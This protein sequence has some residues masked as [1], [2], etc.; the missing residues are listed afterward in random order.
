MSQIK[1]EVDADSVLRQFTE[2]E[3]R[4]L[5]FAVMRAA[6]STAEEVQYQWRRLISTRLDSPVSLT[7][8]SVYLKKARYT[9]G[10]DG[11]RSTEAAEVYIRDEAAKG[12]PP[13]KYLLAQVLGGAGRAKGIDRG[14]QRAGVLRMGERAIPAHDSTLLDAHGNIKNGVVAQI[15]SQLGGQF[16]ILSNESPA[17]KSA[18]N[19]RARG[20]KTSVAR[21]RRYFAKMRH[22]ED[23]DAI[24]RTRHLSPG[25]Y[26]RDGKHD[27]TKVFHFV[28]ATPQYTPRLDLFGAAGKAWNSVF[29]FFMERELAKAVQDSIARGYR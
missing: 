28:G 4:N 10:S 18:R 12:T 24:A 13:A 22:G 25:I 14:L 17:A 11:T 1:I 8:K 29:P 15:L 7:L 2:L 27:L 6:N 26:L 23:G 3:Q 21:N 19:K 20:R 16:D 5:P 9:R